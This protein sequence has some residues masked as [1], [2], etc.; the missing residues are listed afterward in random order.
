MASW[1]RIPKVQK[2][3]QSSNGLSAKIEETKEN[4]WGFSH[5]CFNIENG[6]DL[7]GNNENN[8]IYY[9]IWLP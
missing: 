3:P 6:E 8:F 1:Q 5:N 2:S 4:I 7:T 9:I